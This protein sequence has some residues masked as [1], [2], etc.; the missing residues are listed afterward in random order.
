MSDGVRFTTRA[1]LTSGL[2]NLGVQPGDILLVHARMSALGYVPGAARTVVEAL[3]EA[4]GSNGT[5]MMP[6]YSG[7]LSDPAEWRHPPAP[8]EELASI[9]ASIPAYDPRLTPTLRMGTVAEYFRTYPDCI[10]SPHP[11]SSFC[12]L[13]RHALALVGTHPPDDRF[14]LH[15][16][17]G[18]L[19]RLRGKSLLLGAPINS[20]SLLYLAMYRDSGNVRQNKS[21]PILR[22][23]EPCWITYSDIQISDD[24]FA[25]FTADVLASGVVRQGQVCGATCHLFPA[26]ETT[27]AAQS[28][29]ARHGFA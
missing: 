20:N 16:P 3:V 27:D 8:P 28:W 22:N 15:S 26:A 11:Q 23:G 4:V 6:T 19:V 9:R 29:R 18:A 2:T 17:L 14:G 1:E 13:G 25:D 7:D 5:I 24:W 21:A 10:R 12:A